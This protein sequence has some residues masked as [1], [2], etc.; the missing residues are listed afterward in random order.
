M[1]LIKEH[2]FECIPNSHVFHLVPILGK[3]DQLVLTVENIIKVF[4]HNPFRLSAC[5]MFPIPS[6][7]AA[8]IPVERIKWNLYIAIPYHFVVGIE[9]GNY[10]L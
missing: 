2:T 4:S 1:G 6:S 9:L 8:T 5:V 10:T 3:Y 7:I